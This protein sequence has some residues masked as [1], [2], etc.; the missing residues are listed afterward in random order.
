M[1]TAETPP[2]R[3]WQVLDLFWWPLTRDSAVYGVSILMMLAFCHDG[4]VSASEAA[5]LTIMYFVYLAIM[6]VNPRIVGWIHSRSGGAGAAGAAPPSDVEMT[7]DAGLSHLAAEGSP[8]AKLAS[9]STRA[10]RSDELPPAEEGGIQGDVAADSPGGDAAAGGE[11][12]EAR[13]PF[14][15]LMV[16]LS[17]PMELILAWT[18]PDCR[19]EKWGGRWYMATFGMSILWIG[20]L[21]FLMVDFASRAA[22]VLLVPELLIGLVVLSVGTSVPDALSSIIV[23]KQG[24]GNMAVCN[25]LGSNVFNILLGNRRRRGRPVAAAPRGLAP[26]P[27]ARAAPSNPRRRPR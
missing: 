25:A 21:S 20:I 2:S 1:A 24:Q 17:K 12:E 13:G 22:C 23:A 5:A 4:K 19:E 7:E 27:R 15:R 8:A 9:S 3:V 11:D 14:G 6:V 16:L 10:M 26:R 18:I